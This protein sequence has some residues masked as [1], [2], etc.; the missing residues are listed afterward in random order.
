VLELAR[1]LTCQ[2]VNGLSIYFSLSLSFVTSSLFHLQDK[3]VFSH[4][5]TPGEIIAV[6]SASIKGATAFE[7]SELE[8]MEIASSEASCSLTFY[9]ELVNRNRDQSV[10]DY[11]VMFFWFVTAGEFCKTSIRFGIKWNLVLW[12]VLVAVK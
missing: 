10:S 2:R 9:E 5:M 12:F 7:V 6:S 11:I 4:S 3:S 1:N 8:A